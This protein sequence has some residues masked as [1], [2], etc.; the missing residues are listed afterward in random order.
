MKSSALVFLAAFIALAASW[1]G[2]VLAPQ[3][4]LGQSQPTAVG[5]GSDLYPL[6]RPGLA[7]QGAE[8]Y[9][10]LGCVYCHS[11]QVGQEGVQAE[12]VLTDAGTNAAATLAVLGKLNSALAN[13]DTLTALPKTLIPVAD[14]SA[15]API[16]KAIASVGAKVQV[17]VTALGPDISRGWGRRRTVAQDYVYDLPVQPGTRRAGPDLANV[18]S[19]LPDA[20]W[21]LRHLYAPRADVVGSTMPPYRFLFEKRRVSKASDALQLSGEFAATA[22]YEIIPTEDARALAAYLVSLRAET[23][24]FEAPFTAPTA[25]EVST[26]APPS[27]NKVASLPYTIGELQKLPESAK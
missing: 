13:P 18:G 1:G 22:G 12:I 5:P 2:F 27:T 11:Q 6:A 25:P 3:L 8:V 7:K 23:P 14:T 16:L 4:Q 24:L 21:H 9:R 20:N 17:V 10:S 26:N 15:A 19:R